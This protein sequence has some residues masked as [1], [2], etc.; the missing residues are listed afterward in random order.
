[1]GALAAIR[2][3]GTQQ[4]S[5]VNHSKERALQS[6]GHE[7]ALLTAQCARRENSTQLTADQK[8]KR[9]ERWLFCKM[10]V[11]L[12]DEKSLSF[13]DAVNLIAVNHTSLF[14]TLV[15]SGQ[16]GKSQL[17]LY[18]CKRWLQHLG[19]KGKGYDWENKNALADSYASGPRKYAGNEDFWQLFRAFYLNQNK[20][21]IAEAYRLARIKMRKSDPLAYIPTLRQVRYQM[22]RFDPAATA[23]ARY[24]EEYVKNNYIDCIRRDWSDVLVNEIW[25][26]DHRQFDCAVRIPDEK[27][28]WKAVRPWLC[29]FMDA[30]SWYMASWQ[31]T[32]ES[33]NSEIIRNGMGWGIQQHGACAY[34]YTDQGK[35]FKKEGFTTDIEFNGVRH[36]II[37]E[38]NIKQIKALP[39]NG[40]AKTIERCFLNVASRFDK[41]FASYLGNRP[42]MRPDTAGYFWKN[43]EH[44]PS[45][46]EFT[47]AFGAW[48][49]EYHNTPNNGRILGG[50]TP[51]QAFEDP[52][53][54]IAAPMDSNE[55]FRACL[56]PMKQ[57]RQVR[58]GPCVEVDKEFYYSPELW[59]Y[60]GQK[61][62]VKT[63][64]LDSGHV[65]VFTP[66][67][68]AICECKTKQSIKALAMTGEDRESIST[69][70]KDQRRD[71]KRC[72]TIIKEATGDHHL[73][74]PQSLLTMPDNFELVKAG[75]TRSV[76]GANHTFRHWIAAPKDDGEQKP[77]TFREN[78][79]DRQLKEFNDFSNKHR[80]PNVASGDLEEFHRFIT[81]G[82]KANEDENFGE[83]AW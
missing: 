4:F 1:M 39:Y 60:F 14:P 63:D 41:Y 64:M 49:T 43:P 19:R 58:R 79:K 38:L 25:I 16:N 82:R 74:D 52:K 37:R 15:K 8:S 55:L 67:G 80:E 34:F 42:G 21:S 5:L 66:D 53:R 32:I 40:R 11:E 36:S 29:G 75:E 10:A 81:K 65:F 46:D 12:R 76:K 17:T 13:A 59:P 50:K 83:S 33:P 30:K 70:M 18:N 6:S 2:E 77:V 47:R 28:N 7:V 69:A 51:K 48:L 22:R 31:V 20:L 23:L 35:D 78:K 57:L 61:L 9:D 26:S 71:L 3:Q 44:L 27:G 62:L 24:G 73:L 68:R 54:F 72:Y 45:L 56:L